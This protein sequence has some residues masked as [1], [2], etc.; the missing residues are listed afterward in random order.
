MLLLM[1]LL[2]LPWI[3]LL[4]IAGAMTHGLIVTA[5][6]FPL[7]AIATYDISIIADAMTHGLIVIATD[8]LTKNIA[9]AMTHGLIVTAMDFP[10]ANIAGA[11][12]H[13]LI[14]AAMD[15]PLASFLIFNDSI[16]AD[17]MP[18]GLIVIAMDFLEPFLFSLQHSRCYEKMVLLSLP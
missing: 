7:V 10:L 4:N 12:T 13:G 6:D 11:M 15:F 17:A 14:V 16:I 3:F 5:M 18:H 2:S 1:D 9:D 8:F